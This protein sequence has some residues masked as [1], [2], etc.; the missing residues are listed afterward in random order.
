M[1]TKRYPNKIFVLRTEGRRGRG[2]LGIQ[3]EDNVK[4]RAIKREKTI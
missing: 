1:D 2:K 4:E 3:W